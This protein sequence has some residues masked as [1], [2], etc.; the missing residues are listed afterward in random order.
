[1]K[2]INGSAVLILLTLVLGC[3]CTGFLLGKGSNRLHLDTQRERPTPGET[4][5]IDPSELAADGITLF[6]ININTADLDTLMML[7]EIGEIFGQRIIDYRQEFG[8]FHSIEDIMEVRGIGANRFE[9]IRNYIT[10]GDVAPTEAVSEETQPLPDPVNINTAD[11]K[12][13]MTLPGIGKTSAQRIIAYREENG[14]FTS[15]EELM[16][17]EGIG[18]SRFDKLKDYITV[19]DTD[20]DTGS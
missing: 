2:K 9:A 4:E 12:T 7:P 1:M 3:L 8:L 20:E 18:Q 6:P 11:E 17:V 14:Y 13:L 16:E 5:T 19:E 10:V 15:I